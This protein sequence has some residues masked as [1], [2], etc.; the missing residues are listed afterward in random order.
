MNASVLNLY[1]KELVPDQPNLEL[2]ILLYYMDV[3]IVERSLT[4]YERAL[5]LAAKNSNAV[6][7]DDVIF[8]SDEVDQQADPFVQ[9]MK[10]NGT[11]FVIILF[12]LFLSQS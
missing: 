7:S 9:R 1:C 6:N 3:L 8:I 10:E 4:I 5:E 11:F 12:N 2:S